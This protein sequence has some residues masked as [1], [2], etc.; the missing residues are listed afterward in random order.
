[1]L[2]IPTAALIIVVMIVM[3]IIASAKLLTATE[4][5]FAFLPEGGSA[6]GCQVEG[7][8]AVAGDT[9][10]YQRVYCNMSY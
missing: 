3:T 9:R 8:E 1:M 5:V 4:Q 2:P 6:I 10:A 7:G